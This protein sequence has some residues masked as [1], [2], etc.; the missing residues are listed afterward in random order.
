VKSLV[1]TRETVDQP[2]RALGRLLRAG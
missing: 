2:G 1:V